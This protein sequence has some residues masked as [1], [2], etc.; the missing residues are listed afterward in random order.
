VRSG[1]V[2]AKALKSPRHVDL[3]LILHCED[4]LLAGR[5]VMNAG[6]LATRLGLPGT[7]RSAE[8]TAVARDIL[9]AKETRARI[10]ITHV[11][12]AGSVELIRRAKDDGVAVTADVTPHHLTLTEDAVEGYDPVF[13]VNPPLRSAAD[14]EALRAALLDGTIDAIASDHAPHAAHEKE[15][16]FDKAAPG[17]IGLESTLAVLVTEFIETGLMTWD[18]LLPLLTNEP[19]AILGIPKG[20]LR[21][22]SDADIVIIDPAVRW[23]IQPERFVSLSRNCPFR[24]K[25]VVG[26]AEITIV[27]G[28]VKEA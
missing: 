15:C 3:P 18:S 1:A 22:G 11:S 2:R 10:H 26:Q 20:T 14:V 28:V 17:I 19:A 6:A 9:L 24:G 13:R 8:E 23:T 7:P 16:E 12:T 25:E 21:P 5:G 4:A 27:S